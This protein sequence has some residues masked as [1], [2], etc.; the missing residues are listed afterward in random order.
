MKRFGLI[1]LGNMGGA[2][3]R[4]L[5][6]QQCFELMGY[7]PSPAMRQ[8][9]AGLLRVAE[10]SQEVAAWADYVLVAVKPQVMRP[11]LADLVPVLR[12]ETCLVS[13]AAGV[14]QAQLSAWTND[15]CPVVRV[16]PNTPALVGKG[17]YALC[18]EHPALS[19][20]QRK[21]LQDTFSALGQAHVLPEKLF[22]A[23]TGLIG[24]GPA[25]VYAFMEALIDAGVTLGL[26]RSDATSM[27]KGLMS[28]T[29]LM[30]EPEQAHPT[31]L[32]EMVT[33]PGGTTMAGL[34]ALDEHGFRHAIIQAVCAATR[35]SLE[36]GHE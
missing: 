29:A 14:T 24:S 23:Y 36:L 12:P 28:G 27:V 20:E 17:V 21:E 9:C 2:I 19:A 16:M 32:K 8:G 15:L 3:A 10:S 1:G 5:A 35:R 7:D 13:I 11:V 33:S 6:T 22:D 26:P 34:N 18:F 4:A 31:L 25:Y 30:A